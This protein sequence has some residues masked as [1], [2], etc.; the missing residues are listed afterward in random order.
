MKRPE[1]LGSGSGGGEAAG[2]LEGSLALARPGPAVADLVTAGGDEARKV[3][4]V[5]SVAGKAALALEPGVELCL[6]RR[7]LVERRDVA[8]VADQFFRAIGAKGMLPLGLRA[9]PCFCAGHLQSFLFRVAPDRRCLPVKEV[10][11][12]TVEYR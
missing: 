8:A 12:G 7:Q 3:G 2:E 6:L 9:P 4:M 10:A 5:Y 1:A 11:L